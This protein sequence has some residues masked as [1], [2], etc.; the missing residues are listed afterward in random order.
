MK[1]QK[2]EKLIQGGKNR[3]S[4]RQHPA[5]VSRAL[6][7]KWKFG[8]KVCPICQHERKDPEISTFIQEIE[9]NKFL[10]GFKTHPCANLKYGWHEEIRAKSGSST[11]SPETV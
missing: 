1:N 3:Q 6:D 7:R 2:S 8:Q 5:P 4:R 9:L 11:L 10:S